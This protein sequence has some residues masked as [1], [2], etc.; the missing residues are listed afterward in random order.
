MVAYKGI[1]FYDIRI[2]YK[3]HIR[4]L[5]I[6]A[7]FFN[8][9]NSKCKPFR[10]LQNHFIYLFSHHRYLIRYH[11]SIHFISKHISIQTFRPQAQQ[12]GWVLYRSQILQKLQNL[13]HLPSPSQIPLHYPSPNLDPNSIICYNNYSFFSPT[14]VLHLYMRS[15]KILREKE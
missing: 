8:S 2:L 9:W 3:K 11:H 1:E 7:S 5:P 6:H 14:S 13:R 10:Y 4:I 12:G 15:S